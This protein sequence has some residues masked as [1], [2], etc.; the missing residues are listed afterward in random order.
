MPD[1]TN[2]AP[3]TEAAAPAPVKKV[4]KPAANKPAAK[5]AV[6]KK[7]VKKTAKKAVKKA[8]KE[9]A[10]TAA[11]KTVRKAPASKTARA[12]KAA[13]KSAPAKKKTAKKAKTTKRTAA[14]GA[15]KS[16]RK[17][18]TRAAELRRL[19]GYLKDISREI[20]R[21]GKVA[22]AALARTEKE[23]ERHL[24][25]LRKRRVVVEKRVKALTN[26]GDAAFGDLK[27]SLEKTARELQSSVRK[28]VKRFS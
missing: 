23:Y 8:V 24:K 15:A 9:P 10:K 21:A 19:E 4:V 13:T 17:T 27:V 1:E 18:P 28:A 16:K 11:K 22:K 20:D 6:A 7:A 25:D 26:K 12:K 5:K 3:A 2:S 14:G